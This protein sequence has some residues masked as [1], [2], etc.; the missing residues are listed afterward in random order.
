MTYQPGKHRIEDLGMEREFIFKTS[1]S[2]GKGGQ[3][4]NK[5]ETRVE[6]YFPVM[7]SAFFT[8]EQKDKLLQQLR[9]RINVEGYLKLSCDTAR[10]Q[11]T[12]K[13]RVTRQFYDLVEKALQPVRER[14]PSRPSKA[15]IE[16]RLK[17]KRLRSEKKASRRSDRWSS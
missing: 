1:R 7:G 13:K 5:V 8:P 3:H 6:L 11:L 12:N 10:T 15:A 16:K 4:V 2:S 9:N 17:E 14:K